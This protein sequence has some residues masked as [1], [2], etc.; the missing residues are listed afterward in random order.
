MEI[1]VNHEHNERNGVETQS[2]MGSILSQ[3][4]SINIESQS[5][6]QDVLLQD[7]HNQGFKSSPRNYYIPKKNMRK[8][9]VNYPITWIFYS[10]K[11]LDLHQVVAL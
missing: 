5:H 6:N 10:E 1:S 9:D 8:F 2:H 7:P 11:Y 3:L 4:E